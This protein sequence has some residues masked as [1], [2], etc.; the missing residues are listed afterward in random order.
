V[1]PWKK[2][3][4]IKRVHKQEQ[5]V[6]VKAR[7]EEEVGQLRTYQDAIDRAPFVMVVMSAVINDS[8]ILYI[9]K[10]ATDKM[11]YGEDMLGG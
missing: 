7:L 4:K 6:A 10:M 2:E 11:G 9:N 3:Q 8:R 5:V 1:L